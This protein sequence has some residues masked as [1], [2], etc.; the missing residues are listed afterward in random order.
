MEEQTIS[1]RPSVIRELL[2]RLFR[3]DPNE[4]MCHEQRPV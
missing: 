2:S 1:G 3:A 4:L